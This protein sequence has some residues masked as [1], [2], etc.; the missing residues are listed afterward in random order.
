MKEIAKH[1]GVVKAVA[2]GSVRVQMRVVSACGTCEG[3]DKCAFADQAVKE[4]E[5]A[6]A[7][8]QSY[9]VGDSVQVSVNEALGLV[10]V[11]LAYFVPAVL[12]MGSI[13]GLLLLTGSELAAAL[14]PIAIVAIY[15][16]SLW[17]NRSKLGRRFTFGVAHD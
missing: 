17:L 4:V 15:Y 9:A 6:T 14:G 3:H 7:D 5:I 16:W 1:E 11:L 13:V 2:E 12:L 8:W 10:A